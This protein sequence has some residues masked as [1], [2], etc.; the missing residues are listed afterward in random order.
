MLAPTPPRQPLIRAVCGRLGSSST[1]ALNGAQ[2]PA[3]RRL[4]TARLDSP[5]VITANSHSRARWHPQAR[6]ALAFVLFALSA[7]SGDPPPVAPVGLAPPPERIEVPRPRA[8]WVLA[9]GSQRVLDNPERIPSL[10]A[11]AK[12]LRT[13]DLFVQIYRAGRSWV[14]SDLADASP[15]NEV[16]ERTG[17][18]PL[19]T[20]I[21][22]AQREGLR[23]HAWVNVLS[24]AK[25]RDA[26]VVQQLG[27]HVIA[28]DRQGRSLL[29][30]PKHDVPAPDRAYY[31]L[32]TPGLYLDPAAPGL[33][34]HLAAT[35]AEMLIRYPGLEGLH[36]DYIRYPDVL[37]FTPGSRFGVGLDFGYGEP[38]RER[39]RQETGLTAPFGK[40]LGN[41]NAWDK[42]RRD[43]LT[44]LV[45]MISASARA[46]RQNVVLSAAV[47]TYAD[48]GYLAL[49]QDW[50][51]WLERDLL[52]LAVPMSYTLDD[53]LLRYQAQSFAGLPYGDRIWV[54][55]GSWLFADDPAR[56]VRQVDAV[57][58]A[59]VV[60][61]S[62]FS[63]DSIVDT[64][65]LLDA[66]VAAA[67]EE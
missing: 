61:D 12:R 9:E 10:I 67:N 17:L 2:Y 56:A 23:V 5:V 59:G 32:G 35:F 15:Y 43:K 25:N 29:D 57:R 58:T 54:G 39:F 62:L 34:E 8:L 6:M 65:L 19:A 16:F 66:L 14:A 26:P 4:L 40:G 60:A 52:D 44:E 49:G 51:G 18:D 33:A 27:P 1:D 3:I 13:T 37:P 53:T 28:V 45:A 63:Y 38:T 24:L 21:E 41:A 20:L 42:W 48:R 50:R 7:C 64:P 36:L 11:D 22:S 31:R 30:Y 55:L 46:V 47:W